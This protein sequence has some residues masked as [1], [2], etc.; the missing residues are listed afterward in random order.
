V[1]ERTSPLKELREFGFVDLAGAVIFFPVVRQFGL[2]GEGCSMSKDAQ[3]QVV[4]TEEARKKFEECVAAFAACGFGPEGPPLETT[5]A[6]IE[7]FG[8]EVGKMVARALD[9]KLA[10]QHAAH[11]QG[12]APCPCCGTECHIKE[13]SNTRDLQT[14]DGNVPLREPTCHCPVCNRD[15]FPSACRVE[16]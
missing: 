3:K 11:F 12:T 10:H 15:F 9:A 8:H 6:E 1:Q 4:L 13:N 16:D 2:L 5:F 7:E 14:T